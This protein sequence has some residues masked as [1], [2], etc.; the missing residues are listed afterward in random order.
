MRYFLLDRLPLLHHVHPL[1]LL[2]LLPQL[3]RQLLRQLP[4]LQLHKVMHT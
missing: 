2:S 1:L 3:L 4:L